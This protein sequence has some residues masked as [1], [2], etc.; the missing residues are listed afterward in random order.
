MTALELAEHGPMVSVPLDDVTGRALVQSGLVDAAPDPDV[1]GRWRVRAGGKVGVAAVHPPGGPPVTLRIAPKVP[2]A[3]FLFLL[4]YARVPT[5][6]RG[7]HVR[8]GTETE[9]LPASARLFASQA[10][11]ALRRGLLTGYRSADETA[12]VVRGRIR[13]GDQLRRHHGRLIP[14]EISHN[15]H[16]PDIAENRVLRAACD[17]LLRLPGRLATEVQ[18]RLLRLR[19]RLAGITPVTRGERL[20]AW[21]PSRLNARYHPALRLAELVVRGESVEHR[22]GDVT[23]HGFMF[24]MAKV[25]EDFVTTALCDALAGHDGQCVRQA[26]HHLDEHNAIRMVPDFVRYNTDGRPL[27][28]ADAKYK[29][30]RPAGYPDADLYQM[31]AYCTALNLPEGHLVYAKGNARHG[32]HRVRNAGITIHQHALDLNLP[33]AELLDQLHLIADRFASP[34]G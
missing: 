18:G 20:P 32:V 1:P 31:L 7:E 17:T 29:A 6:W 3:R 16:T 33:P 24:D 14:L 9:L 11:E 2:I 10:G 8:V 19:V 12:M 34:R 26:T 22:P 5:G 27:A 15:E 21:L 4:G 25:F 13:L 23:V 28:V 30:E